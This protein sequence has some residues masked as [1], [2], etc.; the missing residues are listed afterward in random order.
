MKVD[1][2]QAEI[3]KALRGIG[4]KAHS[5]SIVG[6]GF[7]DL[8]VIFRGTTVLLEVKNPGPPS[9]RALTAKEAAFHASWPGEIPIVTTPAEA[10]VAVVSAARPR[11]C[12]TCEQKPQATR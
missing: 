12:P 5:T 3:V 11:P 9:S 8:A 1:T 2:S 4:A 10:I 6:D 7:P